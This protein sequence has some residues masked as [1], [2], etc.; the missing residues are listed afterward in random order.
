MKECSVCFEGY[1]NGVKC[2]GSCSLVICIGCFNKILNINEV[3]DICMICPQ[4]RHLSVKNLDNKF[5]KFLNNNKKCLKRIV[6][7]LENHI[8]NESKR[9]LE[10]TWEAFNTRVNEQILIHLTPDQLADIT[11]AES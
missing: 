4:C 1:K 5:T 9:M 11:Y 8:D 7:L 2:F 10:N 6:F 3:Q